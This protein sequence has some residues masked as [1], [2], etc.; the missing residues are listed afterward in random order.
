[1]AC[2]AVTRFFDPSQETK[3]QARRYKKE[4]IKHQLDRTQIANT[5]SKVIT[6]AQ[7]QIRD[8]DDNHDEEERIPEELREKNRMII[9][10]MIVSSIFMRKV[11]GI[12]MDAID[13]LA[14]RT[15]QRYWK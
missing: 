4:L 10:E 3:Y 1:M 6:L 14:I 7:I 11:F 2:L 5:C 8:N 13:T 15:C 9:H 12:E